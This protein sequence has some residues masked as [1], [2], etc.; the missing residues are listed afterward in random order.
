M[1]INCNSKLPYVQIDNYRILLDTGSSIN[2]I[3]PGFIK[4]YLPHV[5]THK[6]TFTFNTATGKSKGNKY[7]NLKIND[8]T[9]KCHVYDFHKNFNLLLGFEILK[10]LKMKIDFSTELVYCNN[11]IY[12]LQY[13]QSKSENYSIEKVNVTR[14]IRTDHLN[15]LEK[16]ALLNIVKNYKD[17]FPNN[18]EKLTH[19]STIKHKIKLKDDT[20]IYTKNY[21][22]PQTLKKD[23]QEHIT[24]LLDNE[25]IRESYSPWSSPIWIVPKKLDASKKRKTR[26]VIDYRKLNSQTIDDKFPIP[27]ITEIL[28][29]L[30]RSIYF[31]TLD[32]T[33]GFHQIE[34]DKDDIEKTAFSTD[35]GHFEFTRMPFGL[36][37]AP[38][39]FQRLM[40]TILK[41]YINKICLVYLD[42]IIIL[43][44]SLQEHTENVI[45]IF[46]KLREHN[47]TIQLDKSEFFRK[48]VAYLGHIISEDGIKPNPDKITAI[49]NFPIPKTRKELK[50]YLGLIGYYRRFI[51]NFAKITKPLTSRLKKDTKIDYNNEEYIKCFNLC[52][53]LLINEPILKYPDFS[54]PFIVT[55]DAS[56]YALG[57]VLSQNFNGVEHPIGYSSRTLNTHEIN[58]STT[59]KELLAIVW[60][61]N[62]FRPYLYGTK[63]HIRTDHKPLVWLFNLKDPNSKLSR[64][65][66]KLEEYNYDIEYKAG[67]INT[68]ADAL[69]RIRPSFE[70]NEIRGNILDSKNIAHFISKDFKFNSNSAKD[71]N[72]TFNSKNYCINRNTQ[73]KVGDV[74]KQ[75]VNAE[76]NIFHLIVNDEYLKHIENTYVK[77][78]LI[79]LKEICIRDEIFEL[80]IPKLNSQNWDEIKSLIVE[81]FKDD[82]IKINIIVE[83]D[84]ENYLHSDNESMLAQ[85]DTDNITVH[86]A[87]ENEN[88]GITFLNQRV[89]V[90]SNQILFSVHK[91]ETNIQIQKLYNNKKQRF[92]VQLQNKKLE[93]EI[94]EF[95]KNYLQPKMIYYCLFESITLQQTINKILIENFNKEAPTIIK[96][97]NLVQD[98]EERDEQLQHVQNYHV[99]KTNHRGIVESY[100]KLKERYYW[101]N[102][103]ND[104]TRFINNCDICQKVKYER[105]PFKDFNNLTPTASLP[106]EIINIDTLSL[107]KEKYLTIIDQFSKFAQ[108]YK[109]NT[110][111]ALEIT[112]SL[113]EFFTQYKVPSKIIHDPGTEFNNSL[114]K[115]LLNN[116]G[117]RIHVTSVAN[118]KSNAIIERFHSTFIEHL[119]IMS[120]DK[121]FS[122]NDINEKIKFAIIAYNNSR[123]SV[124]ELTP[125]EVIFGKHE[126]N[127]FPQD[128]ILETTVG[129]HFAKLKKIHS[130]IKNKLEGEKKDRFTHP[131]NPTS[132]PSKIFIKEDPRRI[133][134]IN[135]ELFKRKDVINY[136][137]E[138]GVVT[139]S[140]N[141]KH[142]VN[143]LKK[144]R[145]F[146]TDPATA[147]DKT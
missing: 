12:K 44:T 118:P 41:D 20:P 103:Q 75:I 93:T 7:V 38:A 85:Y 40:N 82:R 140:H 110:A 11:K 108:V 62:Y 97:K 90:G 49:K 52:K 47:L 37:N 34:V 30:G 120:L 128:K 121:K 57:A 19:T 81:I 33:S 27:N 32:L 76:T 13:L 4:K 145:K 89:N 96:C 122:T 28:D 84:L 104:I 3:H 92:I 94:F 69:S 138:L 87:E 133:G 101:P 16:E 88:N 58:Y 125:N 78:A 68:N 17:L 22:L 80:N 60:A 72:K 116:Y 43:G 24:K 77:K 71:I 147:E 55:T 45:K 23:V 39:T 21:R 31:T 100:E 119:R 112:N 123:H 8:I 66:E 65:K 102:M 99:G 26:L 64:W 86:S 5:K 136:D 137:E 135:K 127:L 35:Q 106:F 1:N 114:V 146:V 46:K 59:E 50:G 98:V 126:I 25:I 51:E 48:E 129:D 14:L 142:K 2:L 130:I 95:I 117:I 139:D 115:N 56:N 70:I 36:K 105:T 67:K 79:S 53:T 10:D 18:D 132:L 63:F 131:E 29:K 107:N 42:D 143:K 73:D 83:E 91:G 113:I 141:K 15:D 124:T 134:K 9:V 109:L 54:E 61:T 111:N 74:I 144:P 6:E